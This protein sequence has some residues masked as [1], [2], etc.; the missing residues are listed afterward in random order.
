MET[1]KKHCTSCLCVGLKDFSNGAATTPL[2]CSLEDEPCWSSLPKS[3]FRSKNTA[4]GNCASPV[5]R[6]SL[7]R[8]SSTLHTSMANDSANYKS[9]YIRNDVV[10]QEGRLLS[11]GN[12]TPVH[13]CCYFHAD[14][15]WNIYH[16]VSDDPTL[17]M[18]K[19]TSVLLPA[20]DSSLVGTCEFETSK[21]PSSILSIGQHFK[22]TKS[23]VIFIGLLSALCNFDSSIF[24]NPNGQALVPNDPFN[25]YS[26][27]F[28][29]FTYFW[30]DTLWHL[31]SFARICNIVQPFKTVDFCTLELVE[32]NNG[33]AESWNKDLEHLQLHTEV[34][35]VRQVLAKYNQWLKCTAWSKAA[36]VHY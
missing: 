24:K 20:I 17:R 21:L 32:N 28:A 16:V 36:P 9:S 8:C 26:D 31:A 1:I 27:P 5:G 6:G 13:R 34:S 35:S 3:S 2:L 22:V 30:N 25:W 7:I 14:S 33:S 18:K 12:R 29:H 11:L 10:Q 19:S 23:N 4:F 15:H